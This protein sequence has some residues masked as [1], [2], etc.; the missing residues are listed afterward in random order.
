M[1]EMEIVRRLYHVVNRMRKQG[2]QRVQEKK[3]PHPVAAREIMI[4]DAIEQ[5]QKPMKMNDISTHFNITPA[6]VSQG[7]KH[8]E[9][10]EWIERVIF[11]DDRRSVYIRISEK[12]KEALE[13]NEQHMIQNLLGFIEWIG[14]EDAQA[15]IRIMEKAAVYVEK[16]GDRKCQS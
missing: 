14:E 13:E 10:K 16:K 8:L 5:N 2:L 4:L 15:L 3:T 1:E 6:A 11:E 7:M 12:G 9:K